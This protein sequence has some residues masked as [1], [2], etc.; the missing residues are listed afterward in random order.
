MRREKRLR[1]E[2]RRN[3][4]YLFNEG[5]VDQI[6]PDSQINEQAE[7]L[8]YDRRWEVDRRRITLGE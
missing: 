8:P 2:L 6:N 4:E 3:A 5:N 1:R 7:L